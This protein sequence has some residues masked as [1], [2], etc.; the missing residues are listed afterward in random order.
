MFQQVSSIVKCCHIQHI[1]DQETISL[2]QQNKCVN[3]Q[4]F[5]TTL[6]TNDRPTVIH[7]RSTQLKLRCKSAAY[8]QDHCA[9]LRSWKTLP[10]AFLPPPQSPIY[11]HLWVTQAVVYINILP[12]WTAFN[13]TAV[14]TEK[15]SWQF[16]NYLLSVLYLLAVTWE[17]LRLHPTTHSP[18]S[19]GFSTRLCLSPL[20]HS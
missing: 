4:G 18:P 17:G 5:E 16:L 19:G 10:N 9:L 12:Y 6:V 7:Q 1:N 11:I 13:K 8:S 15:R 14:W 3:I 2:Q 20:L